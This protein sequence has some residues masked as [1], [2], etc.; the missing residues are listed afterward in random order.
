MR[1]LSSPIPSTLS[2]RVRLPRGERSEA[3]R[4][5]VVEQLSNIPAKNGV[6]NGTTRA[7]EQKTESRGVNNSK[8]QVGIDVYVIIHGLLAP[9]HGALESRVHESGGVDFPRLPGLDSRQ[10]DLLVNSVKLLSFAF[11]LTKTH[12]AAVG[13]HSPQALFP[14]FRAA[15]EGHLRLR[16]AFAKLRTR[17]D[18]SLGNSAI[19]GLVA[20]RTRR[21]TFR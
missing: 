13:L 8:E 18:K 10:T 9:C 14:H 1:V 2:R 19:L 4:N 16:S 7:R 6:G 11:P 21:E 17:F 5:V 3:R 20:D 15:S 12:V